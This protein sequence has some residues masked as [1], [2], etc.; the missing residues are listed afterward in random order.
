MS[1][2]FSRSLA[3]VVGALLL[4]VLAAPALAQERILAYDSEVQINADGSLDVTERIRVRAEGSNIRRGIYRDFPT[5][6]EDRYGNRVVVD[7][8]PIEVLRD[9]V[10]EAWFTEELSNGV[11]LN[12]GNDDF[13]PVPADY[14]YTLRFRTTRQLGFFA[15][16]DELYW[17]AIGNGWIFDIDTAR[18]EVR[19]PQAVAAEQMK[20]EAYTGYE[21]AQGQDYAA[22]IPAPGTAL[23]T[24]TRPLAANE[25]LTIV[26]SF[27]KGLV[28]APT[29]KQQLL[30]FLRDN[31]GVLVAL[32]GLLV[33]AAFCYLRW[34][35]VGRDPAAGVIITRYEPPAGYSP[36]GLR[37]LKKMGYDMRCFSADVLTLAVEGKLNVHGDAGLFA[38]W[39]LENKE[40][41]QAAQTVEE[42]ALF[43]KLFA[44]TPM[45][46]LHHSNHRIVSAARSAHSSALEKRFE[47]A[48]FKSNGGSVG[49]AIVITMISGVAAS[50]VGGGAGL[51]IIIGIMVLMLVIVIAFNKLV[52]APTL[53]GRKLIDEI[54]GFKSYMRVA[55]RDELNRLTGPGGAPPS[56]D[57]G[58]YEKMLPY[59]VALDVED[60]WTEKF[61]LAA[62]AAAVAAATTGMAW[63]RGSGFENI[64][65]FSEA[66]GSNLASRISSASSPPGKSSGSGG[67]GSSGGGGGGGGGG[68]R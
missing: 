4:L 16:H 61:I 43:A 65:S 64:N 24:L 29:A 62:G 25:G 2:N 53:A 18:V 11:R 48:L 20:A 40:L 66:M 3:G 52:K 63:H 68:G 58:R 32:G 23:W 26:L 47:P 17:N 12:T 67:R 33:L 14:T 5:R 45:L 41:A 28:T 50:V 31:S 10:T 27:P 57:A 49:L 56:L 7:F 55:E 15:D 44:Q 19:L 21:G 8:Q 51:P 36:A 34:R 37:Y 46:R 38:T 9:G 35:Q 6:Y 59:A 60:A 39:H 1:V 54:E 13:L 42:D 30:W 22:S